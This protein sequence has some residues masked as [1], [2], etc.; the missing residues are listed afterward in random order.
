M[1]FSFFFELEFLL[2]FSV[3]ALFLVIF[4]QF[5][6]FLTVHSVDTLQFIFQRVTLLS[7]TFQ[8]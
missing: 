8:F 7:L 5:I 1:T 6:D 2:P 4:N 3:L